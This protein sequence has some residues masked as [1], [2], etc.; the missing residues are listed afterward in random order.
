[1]TKHDNIIALLG[2]LAVLLIAWITMDVY[3]TVTGFFIVLGYSMRGKVILW[4]L[5]NAKWKRSYFST[6]PLPLLLLLLA[7]IIRNQSIYIMLTLIGLSVGFI[8]NM[9]VAML[10]K[11]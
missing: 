2:L 10:R 1:M 11:A 8:I 6:L 3:T 9:I 4:E 5:N 7:F